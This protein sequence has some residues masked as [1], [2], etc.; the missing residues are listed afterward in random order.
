MLYYTIKEDILQELFFGA[1]KTNYEFCENIS[2]PLPKKEKGSARLLFRRQTKP[3]SSGEDQVNLIFLRATRYPTLTSPRPKGPGRLVMAEEVKNRT[4]L[5][6]FGSIAF[7]S[8]RK[9]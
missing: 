5:Y 1:V 6:S 9:V 3:V 7:R 4:L 2:P 8:L